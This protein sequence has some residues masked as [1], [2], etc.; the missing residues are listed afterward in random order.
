MTGVQTCA[1]PICIILP[2]D[3][4][5]HDSP[6]LRHVTL[7]G[8]AV[9]WHS[10]LFRDLTHLDIR[11]P[12]AVPFPAPALAAQSDLLLIPTLEQLLSILEAMPSLQELTLGN[13]L[14]RPGSTSRVV[15]PLRYMSKLSLDGSLSET[16]AVLE[17]VSLP[18]S[19][20]LSLRCP[21]H[22]PL[23]GLLDTLV[24]LLASHFR[25][26]E[27][28]ISPL[29][30]MIIDETDYGLSLTIKVCD[31]DVSQRRSQYKPVAP[32][33]LHLT[34]G[35]RYRALVESLPLR[36]C[37]ALPLQDLQS[38]SIKYPEAPWS[39]A[40]WMS[41]CIQCPKVAH[42]HVRDSWAFTL[43]PTL[44]EPNTFPFLA[45]LAL[46]DINF[47]T[48]ESPE[49]AG[50]LGMS[51]LAV[52]R[53][54]SNAGIPIQHVHLMTCVWLGGRWIEMLMEVVNGVTWD[55]DSD[56]QSSDL[57]SQSSDSDSQ[58][59]ESQSSSAVD[60]DSDSWSGDSGDQ[61]S[62]TATGTVNTVMI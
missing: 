46:Q 37:K 32:A 2:S 18:S 41:V 61:G 22:N 38:L 28:S 39:I 11:I 53:E 49:D 47:Y 23:D 56:S 44:R 4:F 29:S 36:V 51:L 50:P 6:K 15:V 31:T 62:N 3:L 7:I 25:A 27:T 12:P 58:S 45:T 5:A 42:L 55:I 60:S 54:R 24:S 59:S 9:P 48:P 52:L 43:V 10:P 19:A 35:S 17:R 14:P 30:T 8:C 57:D 1:L 34:F 33:R 13:C 40:D 26:P 20:S 16:V 21:D